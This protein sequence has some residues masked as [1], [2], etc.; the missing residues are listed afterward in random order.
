M[1]LPFLYYFRS[2]TFSLTTNDTLFIQFCFKKTYDVIEKEKKASYVILKIFCKKLSFFITAYDDGSLGTYRT[3]DLQVI[4][5]ASSCCIIRSLSWPCRKTSSWDR[6]PYNSRWS[7]WRNINS[8]NTTS[9][10]YMLWCIPMA[11]DGS[12]AAQILMIDW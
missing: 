11:V 12:L 1:L 4:A 6:E 7:D 2:Q 9:Q 3:S 10:L 8:D 5:R